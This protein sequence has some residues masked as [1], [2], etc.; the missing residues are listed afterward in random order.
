MGKSTWF[1]QPVRGIPEG[2][3]DGLKHH[4]GQESTDL[5]QKRVPDGTRW[6]TGW[7]LIA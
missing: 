7:F 4:M 6:V 1:P 3:L 2:F 5:K